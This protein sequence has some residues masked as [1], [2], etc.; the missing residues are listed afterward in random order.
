MLDQLNW[1]ESNLQ[2][3]FFLSEFLALIKEECKKKNPQQNK[4]PPQKPSKKYKSRQSSIRGIH[5]P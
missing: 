2:L 3:L 4:K 5:L 1:I